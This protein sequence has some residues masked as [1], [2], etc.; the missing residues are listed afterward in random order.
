M[1][2]SVEVLKLSLNL[3]ISLTEQNSGYQLGFRTDVQHNS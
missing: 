1:V 2:S 3:V